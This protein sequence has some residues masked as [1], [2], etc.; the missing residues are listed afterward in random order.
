MKALL[1]G[2][3]A[4]AVCLA[5]AV[6]VGPRLIDWSAHRDTIAAQAGELLGREVRIGG[7]VAVSLVPSPTITVER[8]AVTGLG[9]AE[10]LTL[11]VAW[12]SLWRGRVAV[13]RAVVRGADA[14]VALPEDRAPRLTALR[15]ARRVRV[16][17]LAIRES[18]ID[19]ATPRGT[20]AITQINGVLRAGAP[21]GPYTLEA[22]AALNGTPVDASA[23]LAALPR[24]GRVPY[25]AS[26]RLR[27]TEAAAE[28][29][30]SLE[31]LRGRP[32]AA[33]GEV[34]VAGPDITAALRQTGMAGGRPLNAALAR[35]FTLA[36]EVELDAGGLTAEP[37][38]LAVGEAELSG[39]GA[40]RVGDPARITAELSAQHLDLGDGRGLAAPPL[41]R[42]DWAWLAGLRG[43]TGEIS[44]TVDRLRLHGATLR[45]AAVTARLAD[46]GIA[47]ETARALLPG[48][49]RLTLTGRTQTA[50]GTPRF[51]GELDMAVSNL[52]PALRRLGVDPAGVGPDRLRRFSL[53]SGVEARPGRIALTGI[54][55]E[56]DTMAFRGGAAL[57]P[58]DRWG[59]G[60][61]LRLP[62]LRLDGYLAPLARHGPR[63][64]GAWL[65]GF[66]ANLDLRAETVVHGETRLRGLGVEAA[67]SGGGL[68]VRTGTVRG[69]GGSK[70]D[71]SGAVSGLGDGPPALDLDVG[72]I[73]KQPAALADATGTAIPDLPRVELSGHLGGTPDALRL[74]GGVRAAGLRTG[75]HGLL[76]PGAD[77]ARF[78]GT[79]NLR[80][81]GGAAPV[82]TDLAGEATLTAGRLRLH[83][84]T[85]TLGPMRLR[86]TLNAGW[87]GAAPRVR[88]ELRTPRLPLPELAA[89]LGETDA[90]P[91]GWADGHDT[92]VRLTAAEMPLGGG[93]AAR[94]ARLA[95]RGGVG[96]LTAEL[97]GA[98]LAGSTLNGTATLTPGSPAAVTLDA[99]AAG[100]DAGEL[101]SALGAPAA[102]AG[103][104][105][106][107]L[108]AEL[109]APSPLAT[110]SGTARVDGELAL[111]PAGR[112]A[113]RETGM[114]AD[115]LAPFANTARP[116]ALAVAAD[117]GTV[118]INQARWTGAGGARAVA[119]GRASLPERTLDAEVRVDGPAGRATLTASGPIAAPRIVVTTP[120]PEPPAL[121]I[122]PPTPDVQAPAVTIPSPEP[123][124]QRPAITVPPPVPPERPNAADGPDAIIDDVLETYGN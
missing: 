82:A 95:L 53:T 99:G 19:L 10:A 72:A 96:G 24:E 7:P 41:T 81:S 23:R 92:R 74:D 45:R 17:D 106:G 32:V 21:A 44:V 63:A 79:L 62:T 90:L 42:G 54:E 9:T 4:L 116:I 56:L 69:P 117:G 27:G 48:S 2:L 109:A 71:V 13:R 34:E 5:A 43:V 104:L 105:N 68:N 67:L 6:L 98:A 86:G 12:A 51:T 100:L 75:V 31:V 91:E 11:D 123:E 77:P 46:P 101:A 29:S 22:T 3:L 61:G 102:V 80:D 26:L 30:G 84:L 38:R 88:G 76:R 78:Q 1:Y 39:T 52:R 8:L 49:G 18:R 94:Q 107:E 25:R 119:R 73:S 64:W 55:G 15:Q 50:D 58:G 89:A 87:S 113:A 97:T 66:D 115:R 118:T 47:L 57:A 65:A 14:D 33:D 108:S 16:R 103:T 60:L 20:A 114:P 124:V 93:V 85:G 121:E 70:L 110:L 37:L 83:T 112:A 35:P 40:W 111:G 122:P 28:A 36:G 59:V 120:T